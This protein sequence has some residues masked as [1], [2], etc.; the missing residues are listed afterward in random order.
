ML[1]LSMLH[2]SMCNELLSVF[3]SHKVSMLEVIGAL[4]LDRTNVVNVFERSEHLGKTCSALE[5]LDRNLYD[6]LTE[7]D[8]KPLS[9][10]K[11]Q[12]TTKH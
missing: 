7:L 1:R 10:N 8:W 6:L 11:V 3:F 5:M 9:V 4:N 2:Q 12:T